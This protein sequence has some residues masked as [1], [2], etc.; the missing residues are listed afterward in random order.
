MPKPVLAPSALSCTVYTDM[1]TLHRV[2]DHPNHTALSNV[3]C[4]LQVPFTISKLS[5]F[6]ACKMGKMHQVPHLSRLTSTTKPFDL[7]SY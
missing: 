6:E 4:M 7:Y 3:C 5:F 2:L 1:N